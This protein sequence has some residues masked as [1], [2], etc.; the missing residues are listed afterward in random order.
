MAS[1]RNLN[2]RAEY[3]LEQ[4]INSNTKSYLVNKYGHSY[5]DANPTQN[6]NYGSMSRDSLSSNPIDIETQLFGIGSTNLVNP[7]TPI[8]P[9]LKTLPEVDFTEKRELVMPEKYIVMNN[10]RPLRK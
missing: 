4:D 10:Q 6:I 3:A 9:D 8:R 7:K 1:T 5:N 2:M